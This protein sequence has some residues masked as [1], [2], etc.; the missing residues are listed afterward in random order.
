MLVFQATFAQAA[1]Q[2][3]IPEASAAPSPTAEPATPSSSPADTSPAAPTDTPTPTPTAS[4]TPTAKPTPAPTPLDPQTGLKDGATEVVDKRTESSQTFDNHDGTY[5]TVLSSAPQFYQP[6]GSSDWQPIALGFAKGA[7][8]DELTGSVPVVTSDQ[9]PSTVSLFD[10]TSKDFVTVTDKAQSIGFGLPLDAAKTA[11]PTDPIVDGISADYTGI[12]QDVD[13]RILAQAMGSKAFLI[14]HSMPADPSYTF[15]VDAP[16]LTLASQDDG[17]ISLIDA[18]GKTVATIPHPYAL[19]STDDPL[20]GGGRYTDQAS[21]VV[22]KDTDGAPTITISL[23]PAWLKTATF[24]VYLDPSAQFLS[25]NNTFDAHTASAF[26][27][28]NYHAYQRPDSPFYYEMWLGTDP[29][30]TSGTSYDFISWDLSSIGAVTVDST[31]VSTHPYHQYYASPTVERS[32]IGIPTASW[33]EAGIT[34]SNQPSAG[35]NITFIDG[36]QGSTTA[37]NPASPLDAAVQG[38]IDGT[39]ANHGIR[40]WENGNGSTYWKR[41]IASEDSTNTSWRPT[42]T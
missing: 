40:I 10:L 6:A 15:R 16:G 27:S 21:V 14:L 34:W 5:S 42:L 31:S 25:T 36:V 13:L 12:Q 8:T 17:S 39:T 38:W 28:A 3:A 4:P 37:S 18:S 29:S 41:L 1:V 26:P 30:G 2:A 24:P 9:A 20:S 33:T 11:K 22:G 23:D 7:K 19:D 35:A 32:W